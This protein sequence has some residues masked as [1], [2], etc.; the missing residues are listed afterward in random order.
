M[1]KDLKDLRDSK[2]KMEESKKR[3]SKSKDLV[4]KVKSSKHLRCTSESE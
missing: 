1:S 3:G 2:T 4:R